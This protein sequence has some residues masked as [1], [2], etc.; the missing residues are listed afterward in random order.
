MGIRPTANI[1]DY[2]IVIGVIVAFVCVIKL[3]TKKKPR[4]DV[5][6]IPAAEGYEG[7][8]VS[9]DGDFI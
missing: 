8:S 4:K 1:W 2:I 3:F 7:D 6:S 9:L 5:T